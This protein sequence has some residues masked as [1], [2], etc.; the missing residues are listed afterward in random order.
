MQWLQAKLLYIT[1][2]FIACFQFVYVTGICHCIRIK[3][4]LPFSRMLLHHKIEDRAAIFAMVHAAACGFE[5]LDPLACCPH[6]ETLLHG[7]RII[8]VAPPPDRWVWDVATRSRSNSVFDRH[9]AHQMEKQLHDYHDFAAQ[10]NCPQPIEEEM[11]EHHF[12]YHYRI[13]HDEQQ[14][15]RRPP[16]KDRPIVFPGDLRFDDSIE[17][18]AQGELMAAAS[19]E[20]VVSQPGPASETSTPPPASATTPTAE[21]AAR[22]NTADCGSS[23]TT[24]I[25]GG[26]ETQPGQYPWLARIAYR[27]RTNGR[28]SYRCSGS[29]IASDYVITAAHCVVNLVSDLEIFQV[30]IG[31]EKPGAQD[32]AASA[33]NNCSAPNLFAIA[34]VIVHPNYD[35]PKYANDI[36]LLNLRTKLV[37]FTPICLPLNSTAALANRLIGQMGVAAGWSTTSE[38]NGNN[39]NS[40]ANFTSSASARFIRLPIVNTTSCA[41]AYANL[42]ENFQQ[43]IV[44]TPNHLCAQG[45]PMNDVCRGDSGGPFMDDGTSGILNSNGR[46]T[47]LGIV[48]FGPTLCGV[49]TIPGVYT[50]VSSFLNWIFDSI[51]AMPVAST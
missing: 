16:P 36:A 15:R 14:P 34:R 44:I 6:H 23:L 12:H 39:N 48:A 5:G 27:N 7:N 24:R 45:Q 29:L 28:I 9:A 11:D 19:Q 17:S 32:C 8:R 21:F 37:S 31:D 40:S 10:R 38:I 13:D 1:A 49:S 42:S 33:A 22:L 47:L 43:P 18:K 41:I 30:R 4:C 2:V 20:Q 26:E 51:T 35:Q 50:A 25:L 46:Y 3:D